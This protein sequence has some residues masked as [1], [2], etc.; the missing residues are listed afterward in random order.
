MS[1][2]RFAERSLT[3]WIDKTNR[4]PLVIRGARQVGKS[5]LVQQFAKANDLTLHEVNLERHLTLTDVFKSQN[6]G[7]ILRE[8]EYICQQ[9]LIDREG[10]LLFLDE[11]QSIPIAMQS[12]RYLYED[13]PHLPVIAAGSLLEFTLSKHSF[14]MP[15]GRIE[16]LHLNPMSFEETLEASGEESLLKL[17]RNFQKSEDFPRSAHD[18]LLELQRT[19]LLVGGMPEAVY[20]FIETGSFEDAFDVHA[21]IVDTYRDDFS[22]YGTQAELLRLHKVY[23]YVPL[24][25]GEKFKFVNVDP[26]ESARDIRK[27]VDLLMKAGIINLAFHSDASGLPLQAT[28]NQRIFKPFFLDCG[29][30]N[31][32]CG[33]RWINPSDLNKREFIN[34]GKMAEQFIAQHLPFFSKSNTKSK[35]TYWLR[36]GRSTNAEVDFIVQLG[37]SIVPIE[38]KAGK[39]GTLKSLLLFAHQKNSPYAVRFDLNLPSFQTVCHSSGQKKQ[40]VTVE[41]DLLSLPLYLVEQLPRIFK[42][43]SHLASNA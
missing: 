19:F 7:R 13:F 15:V 42:K 27:V 40:S 11:I 25:I 36:E 30:M 12:L 34:E 38:V 35:L 9:G 28:A 6:T 43:N 32:L 5:T 23:E 26:A 33:T 4:K 41:F 18:R 1:M 17:L 16:Y 29:L 8:L 3:K 20:R 10:S 39:S 14:S 21:S 31:Y 24:A 2:K 37:P 22:K